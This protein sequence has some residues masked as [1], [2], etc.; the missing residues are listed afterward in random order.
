MPLHALESLHEVPCGTGVCVT[1]LVGSQASSVHGRP[2]S[3]L[4]GVPPAQV[5]APSQ[6]EADAHA[7]GGP[8]TAPAAAGAYETPVTGSQEPTKQAR[9]EIG[10]GAPALQAPAPSHVDTSTQAVLGPQT[11]PG[12]IGV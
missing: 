1:P 7:V 3:M 12:A 11:V 9:G 2:S 10:I 8:Q 4:T 5:P 6:V